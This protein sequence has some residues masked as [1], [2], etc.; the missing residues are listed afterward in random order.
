ML[1]VFTRVFMIKISS[2]R[3]FW[4]KRKCYK[5]CVMKLLIDFKKLTTH[6]LLGNVLECRIKYEFKLYFSV[7]I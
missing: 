6:Y 4:I 5:I 3:L 1:C 2:R 7:T